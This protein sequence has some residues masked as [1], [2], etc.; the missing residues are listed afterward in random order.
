VMGCRSRQ[1]VVFTIAI[2]WCFAGFSSLPTIK[3]L[4]FRSNGKFKI[5]QFADLHYGEGEEV[6]WGP[7]QDRNSTRVMRKVLALEKPDLVVFSGDQITGNNINKN[8]TEYW[9]ELLQPCIEGSY[10]WAI[11][12]GNHDDLSQADGTRKEL[13]QFDKTFPLSLSQFGPP[14][15]H[16]VSNYFLPI[17]SNKTLQQDSKLTN[18]LNEN[19]NNNNNNN[20]D[21][22]N[23][24]G[25]SE[26]QG[27][28]PETLLYF[29]DSGGGT[30]PEVVYRD[31]VEWYMNTSK[32]LQSKYGKVIPALAFFHI[33]TVQYRWVYMPTNKKCFGMDDDGITPQLTDNGLITAF[34]DMKD[35]RAVFVGHDHGNDWCC[36]YGGNNNKQVIV[37]CF[38]RHSGY[39]GYGNW[40]RGARV[41]EITERPWSSKTWVRM[42]DGSIIHGGDL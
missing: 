42:E 3:T 33:P 21:N 37:L 11:V 5:V 6:A 15:I 36:Q 22:N 13:M 25:I 40:A 10:R 38:G 2:L 34:Q 30:I 29:L 14:Q 20:D 23:N 9:R 18:N 24:Y 4:S 31:Q 16:G 26:Y 17:F 19:N 27:Q 41:V 39:G 1:I 8:A 28:T 35:V 7:E 12:F 32:T